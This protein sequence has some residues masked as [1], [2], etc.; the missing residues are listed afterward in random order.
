MPPWFQA[1]SI[2]GVLVTMV[3]SKFHSAHSIRVQ[4][5][6]FVAQFQNRFGFAQCEYM[7]PKNF[8]VEHVGLYETG[9]SNFPDNE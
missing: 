3:S 6:T 4:H 2:R 1:V 5:E 9:I 7:R 8:K